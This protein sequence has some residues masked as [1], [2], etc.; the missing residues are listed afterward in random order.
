M[1]AINESAREYFT[2][3]TLQPWQERHAERMK[4]KL[5]TAAIFDG[6]RPVSAKLEATMQDGSKYTVEMWLHELSFNSD[7]V[8]SYSSDRITVKGTVKG[9]QG[10][11]MGDAKAVRDTGKRPVGSAGSAAL[12]KLVKIKKSKPPSVKAS[13]AK[14]RKADREAAALAK[15]VS[16]LEDALRVTRVKKDAAWKDR[17][18]A[19]EALLA[20]A[21]V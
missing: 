16:T 12:V 5:M 21:S 7:G 6:Q 17:D 13:A 3:T 1:K 10:M 4:G 8:C 19:K 11:A 9:A 20:A 18:A 15:R 14:L 2:R